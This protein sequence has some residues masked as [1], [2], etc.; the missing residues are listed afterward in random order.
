RSFTSTRSDSGQCAPARWTR[1][2][3]GSKRT[4]GASCF[5]GRILDEGPMRQRGLRFSSGRRPAEV[6]IMSLGHAF[7]TFA[8]VATA[9]GLLIMAMRLMTGGSLLGGFA[10]GFLGVFGCL[11]LLVFYKIARVWLQYALLRS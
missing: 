6:R 3:N 2:G 4:R 1:R 10:V 11:V 7:L 9:A 5:R 8:A